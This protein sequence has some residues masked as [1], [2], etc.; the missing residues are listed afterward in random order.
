MSGTQ[1]PHLYSTSVLTNA[2][3]FSTLRRVED[4]EDE[5][6]AFFFSKC[7]N[8][9]PKIAEVCAV[10]GGCCPQCAEEV[11]D[12]LDCMLND[13]LRPLLEDELDDFEFDED[14]EV[15]C[16]V[17][18]RRKRFL[19]RHLQG[20]TAEESEDPALQACRDKLT[21][22][23]SIGNMQSGMDDYL[24]CVT[25]ASAPKQPSGSGTGDMESSADPAQLVNEDSGDVTTLE[26]DSADP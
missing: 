18:R 10:G 22:S 14:C 9:Q 5:L 17:E 16:D 3:S 12:I 7:E 20:D 6:D 1:D 2:F 26:V 19:R 24:D 13:V 11:E 23:M 8:Q 21:F 4:L 25:A 15:D